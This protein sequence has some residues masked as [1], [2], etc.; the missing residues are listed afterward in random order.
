MLKT[1]DTGGY[2]VDV[3]LEIVR[4]M[5]GRRSTGIVVIAASHAVRALVGKVELWIL[6]MVVA[7]LHMHRDWFIVLTMSFLYPSPLFRLNR[8]I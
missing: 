6:A 5:G 2:S 4:H 8:L 7:F 1:G 3:D